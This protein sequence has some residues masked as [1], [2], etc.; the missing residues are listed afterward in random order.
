MLNNKKNSKVNFLTH[1]IMLGLYLVK[2]IELNFRIKKNLHQF[3]ENDTAET[4]SHNVSHRQY[5]VPLDRGDTKPSLP[6]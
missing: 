3:N 6:P 2:C 5:Q 1:S 4:A